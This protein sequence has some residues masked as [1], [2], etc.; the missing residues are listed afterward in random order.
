MKIA[1]AGIG[2]VGL[3]LAVLLA[4]RHEVTAV[5]T[6]P[7]KVALINQRKS[8]IYDQEITEY[9][10]K[11][12]LRLAATT[13]SRKAYQDADYVIVATPTNY[14]TRCN[15]FDTFSVEKVI[16]TVLEVS[17]KAVI[18]IKST[19]PV[20]FTQEMRDRKSVV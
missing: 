15:Y 14:D 9:F 4:Q 18:V 7:E 5:D 6:I 3:S 11:K 19:V 12:T 20:G 2:Y 13:D 1:V 16:Q 8:P 10:A 17:T